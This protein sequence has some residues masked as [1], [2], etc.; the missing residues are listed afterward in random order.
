MDGA[1]VCEKCA[2]S[3]AA[4]DSWPDLIQ[5]IGRAPPENPVVAASVNPACEQ[6]F[7]GMSDRSWLLLGRDQPIPMVNNTLEPERTGH[8]RLLT[9]YAAQRLFGCP[10]LV[11]D[12]GTAFTFNVIDKD[13]AF[14]GGAIAPGLDISITGLG[15]RC[16]QLPEIARPEETVPLLGRD[17]ESALR[18]GIF[19]GYLGLVE[20]LVE[21]M[22]ALAGEPCV[23]VATGGDAPFFT[24]QSTLFDQHEPDLLLKGISLAFEA[25]PRL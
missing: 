18:S 3:V 14:T 8:D 19:N 13:G 12:F 25:G 15:G 9:G 6:A 16:A 24:A 4:R 11:V 10:A 5:W 7:A 17:T 2:V 22:K 1:R 20:V 23:T 21:R